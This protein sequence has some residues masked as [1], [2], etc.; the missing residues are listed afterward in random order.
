M[1][2]G[3]PAVNNFPLLTVGSGEF[4]AVGTARAVSRLG[5]SNAWRT[6]IRNALELIP[7]GIER[8]TRGLAFLPVTLDIWIEFPYLSLQ[9][10]L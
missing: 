6:P 4:H 3:N 7:H 9:R 5:Y 1:N 8:W 2:P 10:A